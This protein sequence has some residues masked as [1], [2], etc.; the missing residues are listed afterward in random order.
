MRPRL[1]SLIAALGLLAA[2]GGGGGGGGGGGNGTP[3]SALV[4]AGADQVVGAGDSIVLTGTCSNVAGAL[5]ANGVLWTQTAGPAVILANQG[6]LS[7]TFVAPSVAVRTTLDFRLSIIGSCPS[8]CPSDSVSISVVPTSALVTV[9]GK[10]RYERVRHS[11][12]SGGLDYSRTDPLPIRRATIQARSGVGSCAQGLVLAQTTTTESGDFALSLLNRVDYRICVFAISTV[13][14][15][16]LRVGDNTTVGSPTYS[17]ASANRSSGLE[18][19]TFDVIAT[20]G[21]GGTSYIGERRAAPFAILDT[22]LTSIDGVLAV[23]PGGVFPSLD[24]YWS[25]NNRPIQGSTA[26]GEIGTSQYRVPSVGLPNR[27]Y[28][29]GAAD[30]DSDEFDAHVIAHEIAHF[31]EF[32]FSRSDSM[33]GAHSAASKLDLR[34]AFSEGLADAWAAMVLGDSRYTNSFGVGQANGTAVDLE[35]EAV[36]VALK[37]WFNE[38][39]IR[40]LIFDLY[41]PTVDGAD[42]VSLGLGPLWNV[43]TNLQPVSSAPVSIFSFLASLR[44]AQPAIS[45]QI[46][47][48]AAQGG[49]TGVD[50]FG[51][52][53]TNDAGIPGATLPVVADYALGNAPLT[54]CSSNSAGEF[55]AVGNRRLVRFLATGAGTRTITLLGAAASDPDIRIFQAGTLVHTA[56]NIGDET[57][58]YAFAIG[59]YII[60]IY[61]YSNVDQLASTGGSNVCMTLEIN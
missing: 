12:I 14:A 59:S 33:G 35:T 38:G 4:G 45:A 1:L 21:W 11:S 22:A 41:D 48:L 58:Q 6:S 50:A 7:S 31:L 26:L 53:E 54:L 16:S 42:T 47:A 56:E 32:A 46:D 44:S 13:G 60:E 34:V 43:W 3:P 28:L 49:I 52:G 25:P 5:C 24:L 10:A 8:T 29:L 20:T 61:P 27:I 15:A 30:I 17:F 39:T 19:S 57:T 9:S 40:T 36:P 51:A 18:D 55:N 37:G 23:N 2:C